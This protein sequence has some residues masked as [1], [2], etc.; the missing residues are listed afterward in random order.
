MKPCSSN[1]KTGA[2]TAGGQPDLPHSQNEAANAQ[3]AMVTDMLETVNAHLAA[4]LAELEVVKI[5]L[6]KMIE[7]TKIAAVFVDRELHIRRFT[8]RVTAIY[9]LSA[10]DVGRP[11]NTV[12]AN[13]V[14]HEFETDFRRADETKT[15]VEKRVTANGKSHF[16]MR[17]LP[18][19]AQNDAADGAAIV[20]VEVDD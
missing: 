5:D 2:K 20:F 11:L 13:F 16:L 3:I 4:T 10:D 6:Q 1:P 12:P 19:S 9:K 8:P 18:Y 15:P 17:I 7:L 14:Y